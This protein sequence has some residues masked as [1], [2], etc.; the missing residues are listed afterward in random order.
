MDLKINLRERIK[1]Y[2][3]FGLRKTGE[4]HEKH[5]RGDS[6]P[7]INYAGRFIDYGDL[8]YKA[9]GVLFDVQDQTYDFMNQ[10]AFLCAQA[11]EKYLKAFLFWN[12]P[13]CYPGLSGREIIGKLKKLNHDLER[14]LDECAVVNGNFDKFR[15]Q[16]KIINECSLLRYPD[17]EDKLVYSAKGLSIGS[18]ILHDVKAIGVFVKNLI[19]ERRSASSKTDSG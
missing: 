7:N 11:V 6:P 15:A 9:A 18:D 1:I 5:V 19:D 2:T 17:V 14:I 3:L 8:D 16:T 13:Q 12:A 4:T 10:A